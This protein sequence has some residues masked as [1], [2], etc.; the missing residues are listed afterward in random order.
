MSDQ[1]TPAELPAANSSETGKARRDA[2]VLSEVPDAAA[3]SSPPAELAVSDQHRGSGHGAGHGSGDLAVLSQ[4]YHILA[5]VGRGDLC[6]IYKAHDKETGSTVALKLLRSDASFDPTSLERFKSDVLLAG[7][8]THQN[9]CHV[10]DV[11][12]LNN[13]ACV[14]MHFVEGESLRSVLNRSGSLPLR[15]GIDLTVQICAGLAEAHGFGIVH[16]DLKPENVMIDPHGT[17]KITDFLFAPLLGAVRRITGAP[18]ASSPYAAPERAQGKPLDRWADIYSLGV[19]LHEIFTGRLPVSTECADG[20]PSKQVPERPRLSREVDTAIPVSLE[21]II[22]KCLEEDPRKRYQTVGELESD[23]SSSGIRAILPSGS[24]VGTRTTLSN[25]E[26]IAHPDAVPLSTPRPRSVSKRSVP[27]IGILLGAFAVLAVLGVLHVTTIL[28]SAKHVVHPP[29]IAAPQPPIF[30]LEKSALA[31]SRS[32]STRVQFPESDEFPPAPTSPKVPDA[33]P[34]SSAAEIVS[35]G[36]A[37]AA[38][39]EPTSR[40]AGGAN[41]LWIG[42]FD[43]QSAAQE[44]VN[45]IEGLGF[46]AVIVPRHNPKGDFF[47]VLSGPFSALKAPAALNELQTEGFANIHLIKNLTLNQ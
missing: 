37:K 42:R 2:V 21:R 32:R 13:T 29:A 30:A 9:I 43:L 33:A 40:D 14:S 34:D 23:L 3:L 41:Y 5:E 31:G 36:G 10:Y 26:A 35:P 19:V 25:R 28:R 15:K 8:I 27:V 20:T 38:A 7:K 17:A 1:T 11:H 18:G 44:M 16:G 24:G 12:L 4:R 47:V 46:P 45:E 6:V 39:R 22:L